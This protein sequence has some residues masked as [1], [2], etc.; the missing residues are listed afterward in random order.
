MCLPLSTMDPADVLQCLGLKRQGSGT[1]CTFFTLP[2]ILLRYRLRQS[3]LL[4]PGSRL[5]MSLQFMVFPF[6]VGSNAD[7]RRVNL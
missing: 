1:F 2:S 4:R 7:I 6:P 5:A 3:L